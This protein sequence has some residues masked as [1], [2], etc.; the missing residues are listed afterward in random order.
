MTPKTEETI[1]KGKLDFI[2][3]YNSYALRGTVNTVERQPK[4]WQET[5]PNHTP[6]KVYHKEFPQLKNQSK[7]TFLMG[8]RT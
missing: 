7:K 6:Y 3:I 1:K 4:E 8:K 5:L 2:K